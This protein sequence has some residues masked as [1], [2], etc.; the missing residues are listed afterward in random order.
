MFG[1]SPQHQKAKMEKEKIREISIDIFHICTR[2]RL[3]LSILVTWHGLGLIPH[4]IVL[5][6]VQ[7]AFGILLGF[8][9]NQID[10]SEL[11]KIYFYLY[12]ETTQ[13]LSKRGPEAHSRSQFGEHQPSEEHTNE[14]KYI[15]F[16]ISSQNETISHVCSVSSSRSS[17][18]HGMGLNEWLDDFF[19]FIRIKKRRDETIHSK[20]YFFFCPISDND[21]VPKNRQWTE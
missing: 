9:C 14:L 16:P 18:S 2:L 8:L 13:P 17:P 19:L 15:M 3:P 21:N 10:L 4:C 7:V 11:M 1:P 12:A 20:R 5:L 6:S